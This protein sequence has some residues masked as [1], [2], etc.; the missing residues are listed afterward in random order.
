MYNTRLNIND[1]GMQYGERLAKQ[2]PG[3]DCLFGFKYVLIYGKMKD[4]LLLDIKEIL[5]P[6][7]MRNDQSESDIVQQNKA[8]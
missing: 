1:A 4:S 6:S 7:K 8:T 2:S 5:G 3:I